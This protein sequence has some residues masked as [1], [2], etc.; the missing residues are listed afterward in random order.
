MT[1]EWYKSSKGIKERFEEIGEFENLKNQ[2]EKL[3]ILFEGDFDGLVTSNFVEYS[4]DSLAELFL[5]ADSENGYLRSTVSYQEEGWMYFLYDSNKLTHDEA[6][7][8]ADAHFREKL[9]IS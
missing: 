5:N 6:Y 7:R 2:L 9:D 8:I 1:F 4:S 3:G